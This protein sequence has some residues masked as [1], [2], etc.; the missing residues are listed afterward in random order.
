R[1][2]HAATQHQDR[3]EELKASIHAELLRQ[4]GPQLYDVSMDQSE[5]E[6]KVKQVLK[7]VLGAQD[8]PLSNADRTQVTLEITDDI[9]GYGPIQPFL[10]D[11]EVTEIMVNGHDQVWL[12]KKGRLVWADAK[13]ADEAHLR[14]TIEKIVSRI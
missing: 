11:P 14:R 13:F 9:L 4:L 5:L 2:A 12:E 3:L 8:R 10:R 6:K 7:D 1:L